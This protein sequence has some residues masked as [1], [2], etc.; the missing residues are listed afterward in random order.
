MHMQIYSILDKDVAEMA[1]KHFQYVDTHNTNFPCRH[2]I[3]HQYRH[4]YWKVY[5]N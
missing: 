5:D 4:L 1:S 3:H 2:I